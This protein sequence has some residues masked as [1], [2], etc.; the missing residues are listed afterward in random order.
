MNICF[1]TPQINFRCFNCEIFAEEFP[2]DILN[3][4]LIKDLPFTGFIKSLEADFKFFENITE[5]DLSRYDYIFYISY[6]DEIP[7]MIISNVSKFIYI[8]TEP[9][10][11]N[12]YN[13]GFFVLN[14][15]LQNIAYEKI[16]FHPYVYDLDY[17]NKFK[18]LYKENKIFK[19][20]R[21]PL[22]KVDNFTFLEESFGNRSYIDYFEELSKCK[23]S[24]SLCRSE[25]PGQVISDSSIVGVLTFSTP[26]KIMA[27]K[28]L[29]KYCLVENEIELQE[30]IL[31]L[32]GN[33]KMYQSLM[34]EI[35]CN[36]NI[37][38]SLI[39]FKKY[40]ISSVVEK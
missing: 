40:F 22:I 30:K 14:T 17:F 15:Y 38:L 29:P 12:C 24:Y 3:S 16:L 6:T 11:T 32:E 37:N 10:Y 5:E 9:Q 36:V 21:S 20:K 39:S 2:K 26:N 28:C 19:Q 8:P 33:D 13:N 23:Y 18:K 35:N 27:Q 31:E 4:N 34:E 25:S 7:E 1:C